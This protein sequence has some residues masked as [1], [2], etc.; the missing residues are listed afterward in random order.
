MDASNS[1]P[2]AG[3]KDD[4]AEIYHQQ[5]HEAVDAQVGLSRDIISF[6]YAREAAAEEKLKC[7][8]EV[9]AQLKIAETLLV[10][11][12]STE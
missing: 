6:D 2:R 8:R 7:I 9:K 3:D 10:E 1:T 11:E 5:V 4:G 12:V